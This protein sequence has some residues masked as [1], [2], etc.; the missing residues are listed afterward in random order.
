MDIHETGA[1]GLSA[2]ERLVGRDEIRQLAVRY[3]WAVDS[4][5]LDTLVSLFVPDVQ[6]GSRY[7]RP[8]CAASV[9]RSACPASA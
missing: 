9:V 6:I 2:V 3:A 7:V 5:D 1:D 4:R 8:R